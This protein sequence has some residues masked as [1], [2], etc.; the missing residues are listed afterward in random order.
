[1]K[2]AFCL[3]GQPRFVHKTKVLDQYR[4]I[5]AKYDAD[6]YAH[7]WYD[8][9]STIDLPSWSREKGT[10]IETPS[11]AGLQN[12]LEEK[13]PGSAVW[14]EDQ[15][16]FFS[17][18]NR[19]IDSLKRFEGSQFYSETNMHNIASQLYSISAVAN[20]VDDSVDYDFLI[21]ARYDTELERFP[22]LSNLKTY[23]HYL[24]EGG[25][26]NDLIQVFGMEDFAGDAA[27]KHLRGVHGDMV[28]PRVY[29]TVLLPLPEFFKMQSYIAHNGSD[30]A[31]KKI[32]MYAN[33]IRT[34]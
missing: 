27:Y 28:C 32:D 29:E 21:L 23:L 14:I 17:W 12:L 9:L 22:D 4:D 7:A 5:V 25:H 33:V 15:K 31:V 8:S 16:T 18:P 24:P 6:V 34:L 26:W 13:F 20:M 1:M 30:R 3:F 2:V 10:T 11:Y 19:M